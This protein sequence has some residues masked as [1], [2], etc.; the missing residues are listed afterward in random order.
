MRFLSSIVLAAS[1]A[2]CGFACPASAEEPPKTVRIGF[3]KSST[4][5]TVM[6][7]QGKLEPALA[8]LGVTVQWSEFMAGPPLLEALNVGAIDM[9][10]D[11]A[12]TVP[13]F[14]QAAGAK[15]VYL[16]QEAPSPTAQAILVPGKSEIKRVA[17]LKGKKVAL[18]KGTGGHYLLIVSLKRAGLTFKDITPQY[19][20]P[21]DGRAAFERGSVDAW[22]TWD[23]F[24]SAG[25][26]QAGARVLAD[27]R[28]GVAS[29]QRYYLATSSFAAARP[30]VLAVI[31]DQ[32][33]ETG[34]WVKKNPEAAAELL[35]PVWGLDT[36]VIE[37]ANGRRSYDVRP[38]TADNLNEQQVIADSFYQEQLFPKPL[39][40]KTAS[41]WRS[42][43]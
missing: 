14:A 26:L 21:A 10:A 13:L 30:D 25:E 38:V 12:D 34:R 40:A 24:L 20:S 22:V 4:L 3:Q 5:I 18:T 15:I 36:K 42:K 33:R 17:D 41:I 6:K 9:S 11:V 7:A 16:A 31:F 19:L 23:P 39:D 28:N 32:L 8:K 43:T 37:Q 27:G 2:L 1:L 29:Y 35:K